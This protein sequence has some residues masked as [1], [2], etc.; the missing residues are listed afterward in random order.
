MF[1]SN[2]Q[3]TGWKDNIYVLTTTRVFV[4]VGAAYLCRS[5]YYLVTRYSGPVIGIT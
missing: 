4:V 3:Q 5:L 2:A 1:S